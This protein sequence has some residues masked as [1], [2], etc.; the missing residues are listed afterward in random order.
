[1]ESNT[2]L[3]LS[4]K[5]WA[6]SQTIHNKNDGRLKSNA[7]DSLTRT[8]YSCDKWQEGRKDVVSHSCVKTTPQKTR[9]RIVNNYKEFTYR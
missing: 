6:L 3:F 2:V 5:P 1:M 8:C 7:Y 9:F 4:F